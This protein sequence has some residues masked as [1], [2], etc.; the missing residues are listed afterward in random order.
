MDV[1]CWFFFQ[2]DEEVFI[3]ELF[4]IE[5]EVEELLGKLK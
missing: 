5:K 4:C 3:L 1:L 2:D